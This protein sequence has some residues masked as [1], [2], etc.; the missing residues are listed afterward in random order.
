MCFRRRSPSGP[1]DRAD[2]GDRGPR[3]RDRRGVTPRSA[4]TV[5]RNGLPVIVDG[6]D[7]R[8]DPLGEGGR[9]VGR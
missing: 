6:T 1:A 4:D 5:G 3:F 8:L 9:V 2:R 7:A